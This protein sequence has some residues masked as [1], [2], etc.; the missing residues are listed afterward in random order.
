MKCES[1]F[2]ILSSLISV[3]LGDEENCGS[4]EHPKKVTTTVRSHLRDTIRSLWT[5]E[6]LDG[7]T[8]AMQAFFKSE[9]EEM[10]DHF[11]SQLTKTGDEMKILSEQANERKAFFKSEIDEMK[12]HFESQLTKTGD[13][14]KIL[15]EQ[16]DGMKAFFENKLDERDSKIDELTNTVNEMKKEIRAQVRKN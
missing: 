15:S 16:T 11:E 1:I 12:D 5:D 9:I 6:I 7:Q 13:E 2:V 14:M 4:S 10:K 8:K 3:T